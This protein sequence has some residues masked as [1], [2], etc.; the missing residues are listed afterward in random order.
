MYPF[1]S[2][3]REDTAVTHSRGSVGDG[4]GPLTPIVFYYPVKSSLCAGG[5]RLPVV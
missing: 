5:A 3:A 1:E 4:S 2:G